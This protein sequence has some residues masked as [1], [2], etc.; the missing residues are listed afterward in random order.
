VK[1]LDV[2]EPFSDVTKKALFH[3]VREIGEI[4][5]SEQA[6]SLMKAYDSL[7]TFPD[8]DRA[9]EKVT[10]AGKDRINPLIFSNGT[11]SMVEASLTGSP[12]LKT[13]VNLFSDIVVIDEI[14]SDRRKY[15]PS[16]VAYQYLIDQLKVDRTSVW[17]VTSNPFDVDGAK[18]FGIRVCWVDRQGF[19]WIDGIGVAPDF[20]CNGVDQVVENILSVS[21]HN[22]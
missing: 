19:G 10:E 3:A 17:L 1:Y 13:Q 9:L 20:V 11:R 4:I 22:Q 5:S 12:S 15:K 8:V 14:P 7:D 18:R 6:D 16:P 21:N 2:Y